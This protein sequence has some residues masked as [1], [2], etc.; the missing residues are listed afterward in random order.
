MKWYLL[1]IGHLG[2]RCPLGLLIWSARHVEFTQRGLVPLRAMGCAFGHP[3]FAPFLFTKACKRGVGWPRA[4]STLRE[5]GFTLC[6]PISCTMSCGFRLISR[7]NVTISTLDPDQR[8]S[9]VADAGRRGRVVAGVAAP[10]RRTLE[11]QRTTVREQCL[12]HSLSTGKQKSI[13]LR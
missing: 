9:G 11:G 2:G 13:C 12:F 1:S 4:A 8:V 6:S 3:L 10:T 7:K 5:R